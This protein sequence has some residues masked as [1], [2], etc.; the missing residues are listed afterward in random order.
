MAPSI[1]TLPVRGVTRSWCGL[2]ILICLS[3][4]PGQPSSSSRLSPNTRSEEWAETAIPAHRKKGHTQRMAH[5]PHDPERVIQKAFLVRF[6]AD[7]GFRV[8]ARFRPCKC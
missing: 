7:G 8:E 3:S 4:G 2:T 5:T 1:A 6:F